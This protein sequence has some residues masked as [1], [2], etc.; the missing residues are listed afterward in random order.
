[1]LH[2]EGCKDSLFR[3][4]VEGHPGNPFHNV[5]SEGNSVVRIIDLEAGRANKRGNVVLKVVA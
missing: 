2:H 4:V 1:V 3:I 5:T